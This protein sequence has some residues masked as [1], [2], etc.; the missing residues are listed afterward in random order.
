MKLLIA[1][2]YEDNQSAVNAFLEFCSTI[3]QWSHLETLIVKV[4]RRTLEVEYGVHLIRYYSKKQ[5]IEQSGCRWHY[6]NFNFVLTK[7]LVGLKLAKERIMFD[8]KD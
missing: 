2:V 5:W 8:I 3:Q 7:E 6:V 4:S 1:Q